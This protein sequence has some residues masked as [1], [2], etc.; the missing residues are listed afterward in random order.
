MGTRRI[1]GIVI[2]LGGL[3]VLF[4]AHYIQEQVD[5]GRG[6]ISA[7]EGKVATGSRL[8]SLS[9][10]T[11]GIGESIER[12]SQ[13]TLSK[14]KDDADYYEHLAGQLR[15]GG[16]VVTLAGALLILI[17]SRKKKKK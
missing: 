8:F 7:A 3:V 2:L 13:K 9:P 11:K 10:A 14:Y 1:L 5:I 6:K 12:S 4:T 16:W 15:I 17:P